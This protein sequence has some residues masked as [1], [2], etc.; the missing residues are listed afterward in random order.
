MAGR[1]FL[2][3]VFLRGGKVLMK[4][5]EWKGKEE[6]IKTKDSVKR[7]PTG[8]RNK[9]LQSAFIRET[10]RNTRQKSGSVFNEASDDSQEE[11][12]TDAVYVSKYA[13]SKA[14]SRKTDKKRER[15]RE[16]V[17]PE[18]RTRADLQRKRY[19]AD[20]ATKR[21]TVKRDYRRVMEVRRNVSIVH[22]KKKFIQEK[23]RKTLENRYHAEPM[24]T[25]ERYSYQPHPFSQTEGERENNSQNFNYVHKGKLYRRIKRDRKIY[26]PLRNTKYTNRKREYNTQRQSFIKHKLKERFLSEKSVAKFNAKAAKFSERLSKAVIHTAQAFVKNILTALGGMSAALVVFVI[27]AAVMAVVS[28]SFG[29]FFSTFDNTAGTK[30]VAQIVA[31]TNYEFNQKVRKI[32]NSVAYD[33]IEYHCLPDGGS[34]LLI[35]NW[36][37]VVAV[38]S[39]R[40]SG[41]KN[42]A[43]D[44]VTMDEK[45]EKLLKETF[46]DM[47]K[48]TYSTERIVHHHDEEDDDVEIKLHITL[49]SKNYNDMYEVYDFTEYQK[50]STEEILKPEYA[51]MLSELIGAMDATGNDVEISDAALR[52]ILDNIHEIVSEKRKETVKTAFSLVGK[53]SYF[54]GGKSS[55]IGWDS[56]WGTPK[57]VTAAGSNTTGMTIPYG[58]D[59]SGFVDWVFNNTFGVVVG[60]GGGARSQYSYCRKISWAEAQPGDLVFYPDLG[61]V[62]IVAG[63]DGEGNV[64]IVHCSLNGVVVTGRVGFTLVGRPEV[65]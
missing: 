18:V 49:T 32:E 4:K 27:I 15:H 5:R 8:A 58:L 42:H 38:F 33:S 36:T 65:F 56:R 31:E 23:K 52:D 55:A 60:H 44:V 47:N 57:K 1:F 7:T 17:K 9:A 37:D 10:A 28:T 59:C 13:I 19:T 54:W 46:W 3:A 25:E 2:P 62:G 45:R 64:L 11:M 20:K 48:L 16:R 51:Q 12:E 21:R 41:D 6:V 24:A 29:I 50:Q 34:E 22:L 35:S 63:Y 39:A 14:K 30:Q 43:L 53:V 61:H 26:E 40:V